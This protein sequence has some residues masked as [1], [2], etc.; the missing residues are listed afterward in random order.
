MVA[1][2]KHAQGERQAPP[3]AADL[4]HW[5][6][7]DLVALVEDDARG[8]LAVLRRTAGKAP[9]DASGAYSLVSPYVAFPREVQA[10]ADEEWEE[11]S[12]Y[13]IAGLFAMHPPAP[14]T[15]F[16]SSV[17][18]TLGDSFLKLAPPGDQKRPSV[19]RRFSQLLA[20][21]QSELPD[22]LRQAISLL[23]SGEVPVNWTRLLRDIEHWGYPNH[24]VQ[25][26]WAKCFWPLKRPPKEE[27]DESEAETEDGFDGGE[28]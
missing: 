13:L 6:I 3:T 1:E 4:R 7:R 22:Q 2:D 27:E 11:A 28:G 10:N 21:D 24:Y 14:G 23:R 5:L 8:A 25:R 18:A 15:A 26:T 9:E 16:V 20:S 17:P 19:E 12:R